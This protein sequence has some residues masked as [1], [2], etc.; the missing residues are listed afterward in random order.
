MKV[1]TPHLFGNWREFLREFTIIV[2]GVLTALFAQQAV[3]SFEWRQK[4]DAAVADMTDELGGGPGAQA[5]V[6]MTLHD[7]VA[8]RLD[9]VRQAAEDGDRAGARRIIEEIWLPNNTYGSLARDTANASDVA[10]HMPVARMKQFRVA[11]DVVP[12][13][14]RLADRQ[15]TNL[16][17]LR[18]L[19]A[20]GGRLE[21]SEK[22]ATLN[23]VEALRIDNDT[24]NRD[25]DF[26]L[27]RLELMDLRLDRGR[28]HRLLN[29]A[30]EHYPRCLT[31]PHRKYHPLLI[32][33]TA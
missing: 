2:L 4:I 16:A 12:Q 7:C 30:R 31:S 19:P 5:Y 9:A 23:A 27:Y 28:V 11:Y 24:M 32:R 3:E 17:H 6:R 26:M 13:L 10:P 18:A 33:P 21:T 8:H 15:L 22:L 20:D 25:A 1:R 14:D 29:E